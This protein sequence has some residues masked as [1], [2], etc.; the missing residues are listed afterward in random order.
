VT[1][2]VNK[3]YNNL[4]KP[5]AAVLV[6]LRSGKISLGQYLKSIK[7]VDTAEC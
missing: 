7:A 3:L 2:K 1:Q 6:Q 5:E 4:T